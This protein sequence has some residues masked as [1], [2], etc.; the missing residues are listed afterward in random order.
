MARLIN[1]LEQ[2]R[3]ELE[4]DE[5]RLVAAAENNGGTLSEEERTRL[6]ELAANIQ[7]VEGDIAA[8]QSRI[9]RGRLEVVGAASEGDE[10]GALTELGSYGSQ[11]RSFGQLFSE[12]EGWQ[13]YRANVAPNGFSADQRIESPKIHVPAS[14]LPRRGAIVTSGASSG[15]ALSVPDQA[16]IFDPGTFQREL[17]IRDII[18]TGTTDSDVV[19]Y[20]RVASQTN[21]A[22]PVAEADSLDATDL[23][24]MKAWSDLTL[25]R[26]SEVVRNIAHAVAATTRTLSDNGQLKTIVDSF[27]RYGLAEALEEQI[28]SGDGTGENF[29]GILDYVGDVT[30]PLTEQA[31]DTD[32][33][34]TTRKARTKVRTVGRGR[35]TFYLFNPADWERIDLLMTTGG[36]GSNYRQAGELTAP[37][38]WG[39]PVVESEAVPAGTG[40][41]GDGRM[42]V[43]WDRQQT[44]IQ[45]S[46]GYMNFFMKNMV[47]VLA[48]LRAAFG[49]IRPQAF[50]AIDLTAL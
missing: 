7:H 14:F 34:T 37:R 31:W 12:A 35:P 33:L 17:T 11:P 5:A 48:E 40:I 4:A 38:L 30:T 3:T 32:L 25:Q 18:T 16:G 24:G 6:S 22:A 1:L 36:G 13:A 50:V 28:I 27:L 20:V 43:L 26:V 29:R 23:T 42:A 39:V 49:V 8:E 46:S 41:V 9:N 15:G 10:A 47:A 45:A 2:Q 21:N 19:E 44:T